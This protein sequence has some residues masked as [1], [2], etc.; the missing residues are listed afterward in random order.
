M[1]VLIVAAL[2]LGFLVLLWSAQRRL[3][4]F[5]MGGVP[6]PARLG[7]PHAEAV[8]FTTSDGL[9]LEGWFIGTRAEAG[10]PPPTILVFNGNAG[11]R[12]YRAPFAAA[13]SQ[14]GF[15]V[16]LTDYRGFGGNPGSPTERGLLEDARAA[17]TYLASRPDVDARRLVY[18]GE[19]LGTAVAV[20]LAAEQAP[21]ALI[22]RSPFTSMADIGQYHY[23]FLPIRRFLKDRY[24][25]A[26]KIQQVRA[27]T[28]V[29]AG[30][31]DRIVPPEY[32]RM[33][34]ERA[35][36]PKSIVMV[37]RAD[38]NDYALLAGARLVQ[39]IVSFLA[40]LR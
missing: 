25:A 37:D 8:A 14:Q 33:L 11:H 7:L 12:G 9:R 2:A 40:P 5:P 38:H 39:A 30:T 20:A 24:D 18:F 28:L 26:S 16:L 36:E 6:A 10:T 19:S 3:M 21:A 22:L 31:A 27:P 13:L 29:I 32:S 17:R 1:S 35:A 23:P 34:Y 15:Q 4:Y